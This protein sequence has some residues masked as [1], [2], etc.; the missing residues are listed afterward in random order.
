[1]E[2]EGVGEESGRVRSYIQQI[3]E[4]YWGTLGDS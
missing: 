3:T 4:I 2:V 1:M